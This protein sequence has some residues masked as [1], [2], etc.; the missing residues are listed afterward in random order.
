MAVLMFTPGSDRVSEATALA[1]ALNEW[2]NRQPAKPLRSLKVEFIEYD[3]GSL[4][5]ITTA[6]L[7]ELVK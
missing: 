2:L 5:A 1:K 3:D 7:M 4:S 6:P